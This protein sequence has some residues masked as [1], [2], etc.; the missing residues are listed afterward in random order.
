MKTILQEKIMVKKK[1]LK[2]YSEMGQWGIVNACVGKVEEIVDAREK[3]VIQVEMK[4]NGV[5]VDFDSVMNELDRQFEN[6]VKKE[7]KNYVSEIVKDKVAD[8]VSVLYDIEN[9]AE[10]LQQDLEK[11]VGF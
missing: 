10:C 9:Q 2:D 3:G 5:D 7:A 4:I 1:G 8:I 11:T 6:L